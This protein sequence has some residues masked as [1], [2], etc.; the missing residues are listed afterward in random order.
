MS[1]SEY[2][3]SWSGACALGAEA[4][5]AIHVT[6]TATTAVTLRMIRRL[7]TYAGWLS[8]LT[9]CP[10]LWPWH[11]EEPSG[12]DDGQHTSA[13]SSPLTGN[14]IGFAY[15]EGSSSV[16]CSW[17]CPSSLRVYRSITRNA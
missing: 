10:W 9:G 7:F 5:N 2:W 1:A 8:M 4:A 6:T 17:R 15:K 11:A 14:V 12:Q 13:A 16:T 3:L